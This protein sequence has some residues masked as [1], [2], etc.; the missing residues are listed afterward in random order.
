[1]KCRRCGTSSSMR[2]DEGLCIDCATREAMTEMG[3][4]APK[5]GKCVV[6]KDESVTDGSGYMCRDCIFAGVY[7]GKYLGEDGLGQINEKME[8]MDRYM[9]E[10]LGYK[11]KASVIAFAIVLEEKGRLR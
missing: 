10:Q 5:D 9:R 2:N 4:E 8:S 7:I 1:M 6:C 3:V 11:A